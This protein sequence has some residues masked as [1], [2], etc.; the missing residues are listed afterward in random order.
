MV[1]KVK[2]HGLGH[3]SFILKHPEYKELRHDSTSDWSFDPLNPKTYEL[4]FAL[5]KDAME[6]RT[7]LH[8][9]FTGESLPSVMTSPGV[10]QAT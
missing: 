6:A 5:Y 9:F 3:A 8:A 10:A 2:V 7:A 1:F 4:Q